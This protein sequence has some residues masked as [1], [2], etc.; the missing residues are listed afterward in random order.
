YVAAKTGSVDRPRGRTAVTPVRTGPSPTTS[1]PLPL[2]S[3]TCPTVTPATSVIA[4]CAPVSPPNVMPRSRDL[5]PAAA[6][7]ASSARS[8]AA[9]RTRI[10]ARQRRR[11]EPS[12]GDWRRR[13]P[14]GI[15]LHHPHRFHP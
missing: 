11:T 1:F 10:N 5:V 7:A 4:L 2:T 12:I 14:R 6:C 9:V 15:L 8:A 13:P 3:V